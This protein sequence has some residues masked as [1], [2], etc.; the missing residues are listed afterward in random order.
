MTTPTSRR[1]C[2]RDLACLGGLGALGGCA[3]ILYPERRGNRSGVIDVGPLILD[4]LWFIPGIIP[5]IIALAVDFST[6]AIYLGGKRR[7]ALDPTPLAIPPGERVTVRAPEVEDRV[8]VAL[9][10][11]DGRGNV[12]DQAQG[13]WGVH[14]GDDLSVTLAPE[15]GDGLGDGRLELVMRRRGAGGTASHPLAVRTI[16]A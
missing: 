16:D 4:I 1:R 2:L 9:R 13:H 8:E 11:V 7:A 5:G 3:T 6:G 12:L 15:Q 10:L 14:R